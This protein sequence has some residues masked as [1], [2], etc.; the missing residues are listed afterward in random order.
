MRNNQPVTNV[1][2]H[3]PDDP[4]AK[5]ISV[6]DT[7]GIITDVNQTFIDM[8]GY[9]RE[10][11]IG[12]PHNILRHPDMPSQVF[13]ILWDTIQRGDC[14]MGVIKNRCKDGGFYWVSA[15]IMP[16]VQNGEIVGYESVRTKVAP[17]KVARAEKVY[18]AMRE[19]KQG[20]SKRWNIWR[21]L[22]YLIFLLSF[23]HAVWHQTPLNIGLCFL[24]TCGVLT[25]SNYRHKQLINTITKHFNVQSNDLNTIIYTSKA[26]REGEIIYDILYN[27]KE[28]DSIL[29]RVDGATER[30]NGIIQANLSDQSSSVAEVNEHNKQ[31]RE[32]TGE[33]N[34]IAQNINQMIDDISSSAIETAKHSNDAAQ[35]VRESK[36]VSDQTMQAIDNL[37]EASNDIERAIT[38][39]AGRV[40]DIEKAAALIKDIASQTNLLALN[41]SIEAARAGEAGRGFAV[42][43][44]EVRSLSLRTEQTTIQIHDLIA[45][46]KKTA[47]ETVELSA[48]GQESVAHGVEQV[49]LTNAKLDE[50]LKSINDIHKL[51]DTVANMVHAHSG[52]AQEVAIKVQHINDMAASTLESSNENLI[53]TK[54]LSA[55]STELQDMVKRF[56]NIDHT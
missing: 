45:R 36:D 13:K 28:V 11:L 29:T 48:K 37:R 25:Y 54:E 12:Q 53:Q 43:A 56:S 20:Y 19:G 14:F 15:F 23:A 7:H 33:M 9:T 35:L 17:D 44:D 8:C 10:E 30:L 39:L 41:A 47:Q 5:I 32:L 42:V 50:V 24:L 18:K 27:L 4:S 51:T 55:I 16:I 52:T 6:T 26:G 49:H 34:Q 46:F 2:H 38:D 3:F 40:D 31:T 22:C 1:E 21:V